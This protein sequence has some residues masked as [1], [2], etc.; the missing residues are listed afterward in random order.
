M[1]AERTNSNATVDQQHSKHVENPVKTMDQLY[2][3]SDE[4]APHDERSQN[5][6]EQNSMLLLLGNGKVIEDQKEDEKI[7]HA[8]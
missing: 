7:V 8:E 4:D 3:G 6:P 2:A 1:S 5:A